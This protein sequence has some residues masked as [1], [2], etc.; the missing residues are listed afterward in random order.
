MTREEFVKALAKV[1][2]DSSGYDSDA[3]ARHILDFIESNSYEDV[4]EMTLEE[5][6][7]A[8]DKGYIKDE[9]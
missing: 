7:D 3:R 8:R 5:F 1:V 6:K 2:K 4:T 9:E